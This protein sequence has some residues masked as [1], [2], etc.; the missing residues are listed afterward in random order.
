MGILN[1]YDYRY[2]V[3]LLQAVFPPALTSGAS[4]VFLKVLF[5]PTL[6]SLVHKLGNETVVSAPGTEPA[7]FFSHCDTVRSLKACQKENDS[8]IS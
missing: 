3:G 6:P 1:S 2:N 4:K 5:M 7:L 8:L